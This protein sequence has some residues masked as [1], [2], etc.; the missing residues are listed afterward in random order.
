MPEVLPRSQVLITGSVVTPRGKRVPTSAS[1]AD[2]R[3]TL[4]ARCLALGWSQNKL[5]T[6]LGL[7]SGYLSRIMN[8]QRRAPRVWAHAEQIL[9]RAERRRGLRVS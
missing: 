5:A 2:R 7:S 8:G 3:A 4:Q 6:R 9:T 1:V